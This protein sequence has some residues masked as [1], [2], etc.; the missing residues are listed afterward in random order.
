MTALLKIFPESNQVIA[1]ISAATPK[2]SSAGL[3][4]SAVLLM[5][6]LVFLITISKKPNKKISDMF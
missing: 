3:A 4:F 5:M 1:T 2:Y 6:C